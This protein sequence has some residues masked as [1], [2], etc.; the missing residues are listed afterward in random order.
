MPV[1]DIDHLNALASMHGWRK[2]STPSPRNAHSVS[3]RKNEMK[4]T[5]WLN[6]GTCG[7]YLNHPVQGKTQLFR[8]RNGE[9]EV[10]ELFE[11]PRTHTNEGY[12]EKK[13]RKFGGNKRVYAKSLSMNKG[14]HHDKERK[15]RGRLKHKDAV[16]EEFV[17]NMEEEDDDEDEYE[18]EDVRVVCDKKRS[19]ED[20]A[21]DEDNE[22]EVDERPT[23]RSKISCMF[24]SK[25]LRQDCYFEHRCRYGGFCERADCRYIHD[26]PEGDE[27]WWYDQK[28][29]YWPNC[30]NSQCKFKHGADNSKSGVKSSL[31]TDLKS[32]DGF[33]LKRMEPCWYGS[34]CSRV[35]CWYEH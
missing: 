8:R 11:N 24:G 14:V 19:R 2:T 35:G 31:L 3:Y 34:S 25:C 4:L 1:L 12:H 6:T 18:D 28:C 10:E 7:S 23:K 22:I 15:S 27:N 9:Y 30:L 33:L 21:V 13:E 32:K 5:F 29:R 20:W 16:I 26:L 17:D